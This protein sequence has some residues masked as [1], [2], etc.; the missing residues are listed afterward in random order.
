MLLLTLYNPEGKRV[1][2]R[3]AWKQFTVLCRVVLW[4]CAAHI[5]STAGWLLWFFAHNSLE[6]W[7]VA[8]CFSIINQK[9]FDFVST[10][11]Y[12]LAVVQLSHNAPYILFFLLAS[13]KIL[14]FCIASRKWTCLTLTIFLTFIAIH[15]L[16][17]YCFYVGDPFPFRLLFPA[18]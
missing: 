16:G 5:G 15:W 12:S 7:S 10:F 14:L 17:G 3:F 1:M 4:V 11:R 8:E 13:A 6:D 9:G 2:Q 18:R